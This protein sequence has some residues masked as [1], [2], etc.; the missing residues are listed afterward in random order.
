MDQDIWQNILDKL[1]EN[2]NPQSFR[3]WFSETKLVD[4][5]D[6]ELVVKVPT[7]FAANYLNQNYTDTLGEIAYAL[8]K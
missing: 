5:S 6:N 8:Y 4:I 7:Q 3:T 2:I 1:E